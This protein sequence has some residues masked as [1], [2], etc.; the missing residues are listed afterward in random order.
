MRTA[1]WC[2]VVG[3]CG[4]IIASACWAQTRLPHSTTPNQVFLDPDGDN[5]HYYEIEI[6]GLGATWDLLLGRPYR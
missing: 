6:N 4:R 5:L 1:C 3:G 2:R